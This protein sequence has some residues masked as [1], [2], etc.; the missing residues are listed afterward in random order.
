MKYF[1][2][3]KYFC[4]TIFEKMNNILCKFLLILSS[5]NCKNDYLFLDKKFLIEKN[6]NTV[7]LL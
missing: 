5:K 4:F 1:Q 6:L 7:E 2:N 3:S